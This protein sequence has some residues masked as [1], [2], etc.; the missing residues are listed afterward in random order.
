MMRGGERMVELFE[1][2]VSIERPPA[3]TEVVVGTV[4]E[5]LGARC[6]ERRA[7]FFI[8]RAVASYAKKA[9]PD[10]DRFVIG[11]GEELKTLERVR[12][13]YEWF[14]RVGL[15]RG[16][17]VVAV[18]GGALLDLVAFAA[19]TYHR[20]VTVAHVPT[21]LLAQ[22]DA[23]L[24]GKCGVNFRGQKNAVGA[25]HQPAFVLCDPSFLATLPLPQRRS[26]LAEIVKAAAIADAALFSHLE[27]HTAALI[28]CVPTVIVPAVTAA[29]RV[30][31][32]YV[33]RD[34]R[35]HG[36]RQLLNFG[37]T[38]GHALE[39]VGSYLHGE[40]VSI[41][42]CATTR[43]AVRQ[44]LVARAV[45]QRLEALLD[46]LGLPRRANLGTLRPE[47]RELMERDKKRRG[48]RIT[49]VFPTAIGR[50]TRKAVPLE[51]LEELLDDRG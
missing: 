34:E 10:G 17:I 51:M 21:T 38:V 50:A 22:T 41:G 46:A 3:T 45:S 37:H 43:W 18:G 9:L 6:G 33:E 20:G 35:D 47:V 11:G 31:K 8:D 23:A 15:D 48:D 44:G 40:G 26:G 30:K 36:V 1:M 32:Y 4:L 25:F 12:Q 27:A 16:A 2:R 7:I 49:I 14:D 28:E 5:T 39:T 19:A 24:G 42:M 29:L 13:C